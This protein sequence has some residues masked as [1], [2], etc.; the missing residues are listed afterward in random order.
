MKRRR[1]GARSGHLMTSTNG[2]VHSTQCRIA[3]QWPLNRLMHLKSKRQQ[4]ITENLGEITLHACRRKAIV[5]MSKKTKGIRSYHITWHIIPGN[6]KISAVC[7][8]VQGLLVACR[9][10]TSGSTNKLTGVLLPVAITA[11]IREPSCKYDLKH[12]HRRV[13]SCLW[14]NEGKIGFPPLAFECY[15]HPFGAKLP[16]PLLCQPWSS[17]NRLQPIR[18]VSAWDD[19]DYSQNFYF[20]N[21]LSSVVTVAGARSGTPQILSNGGFELAKW[22]TNYLELRES[23]P[24]DHSAECILFADHHDNFVTTFIRH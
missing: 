7:S 14:W 4:R 22:A 19:G 18:V 23:I 11:D 12:E 8:A 10:T 6:Q 2:L 15:Y 21:L 13:F 20:D 5:D 16:P 17:K 1:Q 24:V 3:G 9:W